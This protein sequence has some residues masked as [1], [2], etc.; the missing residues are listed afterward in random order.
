MISKFDSGNELDNKYS[1]IH[2]V[3]YEDVD[4]NITD[5]VDT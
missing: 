1:S 2:M 4:Q 5:E 3:Q